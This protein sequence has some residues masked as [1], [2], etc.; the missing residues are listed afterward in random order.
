MLQNAIGKIRASKE[1][2]KHIEDVDRWEEQTEEKKLSSNERDLMKYA[3]EVR[4]EKI[5]IAV[6]KIKKMKDR[7]YWSGKKNNSIYTPNIMKDGEN[8]FENH[9]S[10]FGGKSNLLHQKN[11]FAN[12]KNIFTNQKNMFA[13]HKSIFIK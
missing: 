11:M 12:Q 10:M 7:E 13:N 1:E 4:Q 3:E 2:R 6:E 8:M 5:K 9:K